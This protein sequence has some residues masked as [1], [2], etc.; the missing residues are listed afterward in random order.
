[1]LERLDISPSCAAGRRGYTIAPAFQEAFRGVPKVYALRKMIVRDTEGKIV[2]SNDITN[3]LRGALVQVDYTVSTGKEGFRAQ[4]VEVKM[5]L[6]QR[7]LP[8]V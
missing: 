2:G 4:V 8:N 3:L 1:L 7:D 5:L 6:R